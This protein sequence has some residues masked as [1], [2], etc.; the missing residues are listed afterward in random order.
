[1]LVCLPPKCGTTNYQKALAPLK[2]KFDEDEMKPVSFVKRGARE[3]ALS[4]A[5]YSSRLFLRTS[6]LLQ[7][8]PCYLDWAILIGS[9]SKIRNS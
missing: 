5:I 9:A 2:V 4:L 8:I 3:K 1:M 6:M 7:Y